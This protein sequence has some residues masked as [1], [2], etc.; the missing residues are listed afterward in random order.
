MIAPFMLSTTAGTIPTTL[1]TTKGDL[2]VYSGSAWA[3]LGVGTND[4]VL[5]AD[6]AQTLG[7]KWATSAFANT[8]LSNL[9]SVAINTTLLFPGAGTAFVAGDSAPLATWD[10][11]SV[12]QNYNAAG[13]PQYA[14]DY[15][16]NTDVNPGWFRTRRARGTKASPSAPLSGDYLGGISADGYYGGGPGLHFADGMH[17]VGI[18]AENWSTTAAGTDLTFWLTPLSTVGI[19]QTAKFSAVDGGFEVSG[20]GFPARISITGDAA[21][22]QIG[23][24]RISSTDVIS[25]I[26]NGASGQIAQVTYSDDANPGMIK[27]RKAR[28]SLASPTAVQSGD[29]IGRFAMD[30][31]G[32]SFVGGPAMTAYATENIVSNTNRGGKWVFATIPNG[33]TDRVD[34]LTID[35]DG[36]LTSKPDGTTVAF[37]ATST[38][39]LLARAG[40]SSG[41]GAI[42]ATIKVNTTAVGNTNDTT[43]DD[44]ITFAVPAST[45]GTDGDYVEFH[46]FGTTGATATVK[47]IRAYFGAQK[48]VDSGGIALNNG[49]WEIYG[50]II[51]TGA[52]T[53]IAITS[54]DTNDPTVLGAF[55]TYTTPTETLSGAIT[56]KVTGQLT[57][58]AAANGI[59]QK[60]LVVT[61]GS[62]K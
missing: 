4:Y 50:K 32:T 2:L 42:G 14:I 11:F 51:R 37:K 33:T 52:A 23:G 39:Q 10:I 8:A 26:S 24:T 36:S 47:N 55:N 1:G 61:W 35:Q 48:L 29:A 18:A 49:S 3:R 54:I 58:V 22:L 31:Y 25:A 53:Q 60:G 5:T 59:I 13:P 9:A 62:A 28:G 34:V 17:V 15:Y 41:T 20:A 7:V 27:V 57:A 16:N 43:E 40:Q 12:R 45:L 21:N 56:L 30:A 6:S 46:A 44:L 38:G 19:L